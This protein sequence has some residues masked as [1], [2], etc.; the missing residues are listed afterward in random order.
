MPRTSRVLTRRN[1]ALAS[2]AVLVGVVALLAACGGKSDSGTGGTPSGGSSAN[3]LQAYVTCLSRNGVN[4]Q[5]PSGGPNGRTR[6]SGFPTGGLP[7][8]GVPPSGAPGGGFG[9]GG[10][11]K[12]DGVDD[13][14]WQK[15]Q[16]ACASL[17]PTGGP[18][19]A[20]GD[21]GALSAYRN[22]LS[23]HGVTASA[24]IGQLDSTDP[25]VAAA[26]Q[27]CAA[28]RPTAAPTAVPTGSSNG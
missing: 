6:P 4:I 3:G 23:N 2:I 5:L 19:G 14:T 11:Q 16:Q 9:G 20:N 1:A 21:N 10:F 22:C 24:G 15:A 25:T 18:G 17:R 13:A 12:P 26:E 27:A 28:L 7:S 8:G